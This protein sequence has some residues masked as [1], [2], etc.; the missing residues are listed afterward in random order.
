LA[1][2]VEFSIT[3]DALPAGD[4][5]AP[6]LDIVLPDRC[7]PNIVRGDVA[8]QP[9]KYMRREIPHNWYVDARDPLMG[10]V[11]RDEA[12]ILYN[13][14]RVFAGHPALEIGC[15]RGWSTC[16]LGLGGVRLDVLDPV[17]ED[18]TRR[19]EIEVMLGC[20]GIADNVQLHAGRSPDAIAAIATQRGRKWS[21]FFID[22]DHE[23]P[24]PLFDAEACLEHA[25]EDA[26]FLFHDLASPDVASGLR[27]LEQCGFHVMLFQTMQIMGIAW[28]GRVTPV[29]HIPDPEVPWQ[30]PHHLVGLPVSGVRFEHGPSRLRTSL[31]AREQRIAAQDARIA[32]LETNVGRLQHVL[33]RSALRRRMKRLL[34]LER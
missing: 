28:R 32:E 13:T 16:H 27:A 19:G 17:L 24:A 34:G 12:A 31:F 15:W 22:G 4:Y 18:V 30:L 11:S 3:R 10:F 5:V 6:G 25:A 2:E 7:F 26:A 14:A 1:G 23:T 20:A 21:L 29:H 8:A 9:W 33:E